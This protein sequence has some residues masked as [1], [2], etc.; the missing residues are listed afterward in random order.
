MNEIGHPL[1]CSLPS[2]DS[3]DML[4]PRVLLLCIFC[5]PTIF[6]IFAFACFSRINLDRVVGAFAGSQTQP[7]TI[8]GRYINVRGC[9]GL[10]GRPVRLSRGRRIISFSILTFPF[11]S[12]N[13]VNKRSEVQAQP[14]LSSNS[15]N[16]SSQHRI[17]RWKRS[18]DFVLDE[19]S[20]GSKLSPN[21][22]AVSPILRLTEDSSWDYGVNKREVLDRFTSAAHRD[23][24]EAILA[25]LKKKS[26]PRE[27]NK[28]KKKGTSIMHS[29]AKVNLCLLI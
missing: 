11:R 27:R 19:Q 7:F 24:E 14:P 18:L 12:L 23:Q 3:Y 26:K 29:Q 9:L 6:T 13:S 4:S 2:A 8:T 10:E 15:T 1:F 16:S 5:I 17:T 21:A 25:V 22:P 28:R 20:S